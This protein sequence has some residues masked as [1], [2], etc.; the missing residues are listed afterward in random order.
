[1]SATRR[2]RWINYNRL[3]TIAYVA[4]N[5]ASVN[6]AADS[7]YTFTKVR[8]NYTISVSFVPITYS[9]TVTQTANGSI[10]PFTFSGFTAGMNRSY[11]ITPKTGYRIDT[12]TVDGVLQVPAA[13]Y[14][15]TNIQ[16][17]HRITATFTAIQ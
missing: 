12:L 9:I 6:L 2:W 5:G 15:F 16:A 3:Y 17:N 7:S 1:M 10:S 8:A 4:V 13:S 14:T 11:S